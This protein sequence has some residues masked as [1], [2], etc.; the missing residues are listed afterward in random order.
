MY[1][2]KEQ[3][4]IKMEDYKREMELQELSERTIHK[5]LADIRQWLEELQDDII[6]KEIVILYKKQ[7]SKRYKV[8]SLNSKIISINRYLRWLGFTELVVST[9]RM[10]TANV[11]DKMITKES[12]FAMLN[13]VL[14]EANSKK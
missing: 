8:A 10:Q 5:Y 2:K 7:L 12:Y 6:S 14:Y 4:E 13:Y 9:E 3:A 1:L 11:L